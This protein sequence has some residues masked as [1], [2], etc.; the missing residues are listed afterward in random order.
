MAHGLSKTV[1]LLRDVVT[2]LKR[3]KIYL[4]TQSDCPYLRKDVDDMMQELE[5]YVSV[6]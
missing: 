5:K 4:E 2:I 6:E 1:R 3:M